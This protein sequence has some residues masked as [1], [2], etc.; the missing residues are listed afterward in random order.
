M[1]PDDFENMLIR[2]NNTELLDYLMSENYIKKEVI[3]NECHTCMELKKFK[4]VK[5]GFA[6]RCMSVCC[7]SYK[8]RQSIRAG[9]FFENFNISFLQ[10]FKILIRFS[11]DVPQHSIN[12]S[13]GISIRTI[14]KVKVSFLKRVGRF[15]FKDDKLGGVNKE[16]QVDETSLNFKVKSH[17]GRSATN[18]TDAI[19]IVELNEKITRAYACVIPNKKAS[20]MIPIICDNVASG[21]TIRTDEHRSYSSLSKLGYT[22]QKI[23]HKYNFVEPTTGINT[24]AVESFNNEVN[25]EIKRRKGIKTEL[26]QEYLNEFIWKFN[27]KKERLHIILSII[28]MG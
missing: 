16:V 1:K 9:S 5:D 19:C 23:C 27:N 20:T 7:K 28:K 26:R 17:R 21:S 15:D 8:K 11:T 3:C 2:F 13:F 14:K 22:H 6:W 18:K 12:K 4:V 10:I 24:Q 25:L